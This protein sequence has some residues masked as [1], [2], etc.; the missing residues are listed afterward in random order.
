MTQAHLL[1]PLPDSTQTL[2]APNKEMDFFA[3]A[4]ISGFQAKHKSEGCNKYV[5]AIYKCTIQ[6]GSVPKGKKLNYDNVPNL[7]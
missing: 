2:I 1:E 3:Y 5:N 4:L 7:F 6:E